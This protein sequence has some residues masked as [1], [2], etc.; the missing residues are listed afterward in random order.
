MIEC[1]MFY[2]L[3]CLMIGGVVFLMFVFGVVLLIGLGFFYIGGRS[4]WGRLCGGGFECGF[5]VRSRSR[6]PFSLRFFLLPVVF[7]I[8]DVEI[9]LIL[10]IP[11]VLVRGVEGF[12]VGRVFI[13]VLILGLIYEWFDGSLDWEI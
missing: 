4:Y 11:F 6:V 2:E 1:F 12:V 7:L 5:D 8:F 10:P 3:V 13:G 9:V